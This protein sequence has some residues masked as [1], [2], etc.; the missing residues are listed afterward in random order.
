MPRQNATLWRPD[1]CSCKFYIRL[2]EFG[3]VIFLSHESVREEHQRRID[4]GDSTVNPDISPPAR[5]CP[6]HKGLGLR[7]EQNLVEVITE[8]C[9]RKGAAFPLA[10]STVSGIPEQQLAMRINQEADAFLK[11]TVGVGLEEAQVMPEL[12]PDVDRALNLATYKL[13]LG[14]H[15]YSWSFDSKR[16]LNVTLPKRISQKTQIQTACD[17]K[18]GAGKVNIL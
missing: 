2:D 5:L 16:V 3:N 4:A 10:L 6:A 12:A 17:K 9:V 14:K 15:E 8:E 13:G 11:K 18:F 1:T 7:L